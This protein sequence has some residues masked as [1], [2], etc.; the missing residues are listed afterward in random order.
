MAALVIPGA[1]ALV[2]GRG[3]DLLGLGAA[4]IVVVEEGRGDGAVLQ[5]DGELRLDLGAKLVVICRG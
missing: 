4:E 5:P 3:A 1:G 2:A